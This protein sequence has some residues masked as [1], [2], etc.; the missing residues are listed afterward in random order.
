[1]GHLSPIRMRASAIAKISD[2][3]SAI[4][5]EIKSQFLVE[6]I[7]YYFSIPGADVSEIELLR[8]LTA[9]TGCGLLLDLN[10]LVVNASNHGF[11]PYEYLRDFPLNEVREIHIAG[12]R[13]S[14]NIYIDSHGDPVEATVW[15]LLKFVAEKVDSL[16]VVIERDQD[17][18]PF[19]ELLRELAIARQSVSIGRHS[20]ALN[21]DSR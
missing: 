13:K 7:A 16:N 18:P 15:E 9:R 20:R 21:D 4:Q 19:G 2:K 1:M 17:I 10:N 14:G 12:H 11:D 5:D 8:S 3:I 6:N